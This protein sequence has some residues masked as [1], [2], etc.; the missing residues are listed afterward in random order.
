MPRLTKDE[1]DVLDAAVIAA[2]RS[3]APA[4]FQGIHAAVSKHRLVQA[5]GRNLYRP[6]DASLQRLRKR[7]VIR[8]QRGRPG[9]VAESKRAGWVPVEGVTPCRSTR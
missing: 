6:V 5:I 8:Y 7:G 4:R 3:L 2:V 1:R 9:Y